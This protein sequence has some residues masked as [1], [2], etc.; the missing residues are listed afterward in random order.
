M[1]SAYHRHF[2]L[3]ADLHYLNCAFM[4]PLPIRTEQAGIQGIRRKRNP[5]RSRPQ[6]FFDESQEVRESFCRLIDGEDPDRVAILPS[7]SY[8]VA[9]AARNAGLREGDEVVLTRDQFPGNVYGWRRAASEVGAK[10]RLIDPPEGVLPGEG[11]ARIWNERILEAM[12]PRTRVVSLGHVHW[13]DGS[14][15]QLQA[16]GAR[17]REVD[18]LL[19][20]DGTQSVGALPFH[21]PTIR[22]DAVICATYKWLLGPYSVALG[23]FGPAFDD[24]I[25]LEETWIAREGSR[26]FGGLVNYRDS[27]EPGAVRYDVGE[28]SNF[29]LLP[30]VLQSLKLLLEWTPE[31]VASHTARLSAELLSWA[32]NEGWA[33]EDDDWR[34]SHI[35]GLRLPA[36]VDH[37]ALGAALESAKV[38]VSRRGDALRIS[39]HL[40]NGAE[41]LM[42]LQDTLD[43]VLREGRR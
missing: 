22:P 36:E 27:Y 39:P 9:I 23:Y 19:V 41:D 3:P 18:A 31:L 38:A 35:F 25:P 30:M 29:I 6:D 4:A 17:A 1:K 40:Y 7:V 28:R 5:A 20:V 11:R 2:T 12:G 24:G 16:I 34:G 33:V 10:V 21:Y 15:F 14:L 43:S 8:G 26:D 13:T 42:A 37:Q 32:R